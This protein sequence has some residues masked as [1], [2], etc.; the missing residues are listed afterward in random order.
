MERKHRATRTDSYKLTIAGLLT[1]RAEMAGERVKAT[2][3]LAA[4]D[5]DLGHMDAVLAMFGVT[6]GHKVKPLQRAT[7]PR[8][9]RSQVLERH[10]VMFAALRS[11]GA[12][13][14]TQIAEAVTPL[15][16]THDEHEPEPAVVLS[17]VRKMLHRLERQGGV[18]R[19]G[20]EGDAR[21]WRIA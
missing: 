13:T 14:T 20:W 1:K 2:E 11:T 21:V 9:K 16:K 12:A 7:T 8:A 5:R 18:V 3:R 10:R 6:D 17:A 4:I 15:F 19:D